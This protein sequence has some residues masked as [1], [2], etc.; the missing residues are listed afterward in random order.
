MTLND[1]LVDQK[2]TGGTKVSSVCLYCSTNVKW[3]I[4]TKV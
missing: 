3:C 1:S 2:Q 4:R